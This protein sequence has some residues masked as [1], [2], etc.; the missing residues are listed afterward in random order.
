MNSHQWISL[1]WWSDGQLTREYSAERSTADQA[2]GSMGD[3]ISF[4]EKICGGG[5]ADSV[6]IVYDIEVEVLQNLTEMKIQVS[7]AQFT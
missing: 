7:S 3:D 1:R 2:D 6:T 5:P 4:I